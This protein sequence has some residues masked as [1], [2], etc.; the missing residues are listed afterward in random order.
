MGAIPTRAHSPVGAAGEVGE[1]PHRGEGEGQVVGGR[2][3]TVA[4]SLDVCVVAA[5]VSPILTKQPVEGERF[6]WE[7][8]W[9]VENS[10]EAH[11]TGRVTSSR[12]RQARRRFA[13]R[14]PPDGAGWGDVAA[15]LQ[16]LIVQ[17]EEADGSWGVLE[18]VPSFY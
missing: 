10:R 7:G 2:W 8:K 3:D 18:S 5:G 13:I 9:E 16:E 12:R 17:G 6:E 11:A 14:F 4:D 1:R 15:D